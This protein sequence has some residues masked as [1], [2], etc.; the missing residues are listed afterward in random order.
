MTYLRDFTVLTILWDI[1]SRVRLIGRQTDAWLET[2]SRTTD[3]HGTDEIW[4]G[5]HGRKQHHCTCFVNWYSVLSIYRGHFSLK[6]SRKTL[7]SSPV[8]ARYGVP[9][10]NSKF[11]G[12]FITV[13]VVLCTSSCYIWPRYIESLQYCAVISL[14]SGRCGI[15]CKYILYK[16]IIQCGS[17]GTGCEIPLRWMPLNLT[18][19]KLGQAMVWCRQAQSLYPNQ[20]WPRSLTQYDIA[21]P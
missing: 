10:V 9:F 11:G 8:R 2:S 5:K 12:S 15:D 16:V 20:C 19:V 1:K 21:R 7:H 14:A 4:I 6:I 3:W 13:I 17:F 18:N